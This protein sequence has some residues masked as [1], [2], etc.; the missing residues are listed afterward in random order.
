MN[1]KKNNTLMFPFRI[2]CTSYTIPDDIVPNV[3]FMG[4]YVDDIELVLFESQ[5]ASN[6]P[7]ASVIKE[8]KKL[9]EEYM[10]TY[11]VHFPIDKKAGAAGENERRLFA[12]RVMHICRLT[13][14][15]DPY[16]YV[17]HLEGLPY[18]PDAAM[19]SEWNNYI[20]E[21]CRDYVA[22]GH[23]DKTSV[24]NLGYPSY[25]NEP[26]IEKYGFKN[27]L[28]IGHL[29]LGG[30]NW[31]RYCVDVIENTRVMHLHGVS[32][33]RDHISLSENN[34]D[35]LRTFFSIALKDYRHVLTLE[36]FSEK[37]C[38]ESLDIVRR[39]WESRS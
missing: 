14:P 15:L 25:I 22:C 34:M 18:N 2:G 17:L 19:I 12:E 31:K 7:D 37:D 9:A 21:F 27:C 35:D 16:A 26:V 13:A 6:M 28:D 20:G 39:L 33:V 24:E 38:F 30:E 10:L 23:A 11:T 29:W 36:V 32:G 8:L 4:K 5:E 1:M 3:E